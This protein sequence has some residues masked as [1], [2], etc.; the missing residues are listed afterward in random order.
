MLQI[1]GYQITAKIYESSN[2]IVYRGWHNQDSLP[3]IV[4]IPQKEYPTA[5][6]ITKYKQEYEISR[7]LSISGIARGY[8][9]QKYQNSLLMIF[10]DFGGESLKIWMESQKFSL[11]E[12][13]LIAIKISS[14][15][16]EIQQQ[17]IIHKDINPSNIIFNPTTDE[18]K[19]IDFGISTILFREN[20]TI[21]NPDIL[22]GTL[23]YISPEQTGRMN[24]VLDYRTDFYSLGVTFYEMLA[25]QLPFET[26]DPME[27]VHCHIAKQPIPLDEINPDIPK[28]VSK[29]VMKLLAK[30]AEERYQS[31]LGIK[32]DL[33]K[34]LKQLE[35][36]NTIADFSLGE[37][38]VSNKFQISQKLYGRE[39]QIAALL[40]AF[41]RI[42]QGTHEMLL[43]SG[44]S[45]IGK[46]SLVY[47]IHKP[48]VEQRGYF[49]SG[50]FDQFKRDLPYS[51]LIQCFQDLIRQLLTESAKKILN[52]QEKLLNVFG[53]N[54]Q[55]IIDVIP[56]VEFIVGKQPPV[57]QLG[58]VESQ[59][60]FNAIFKEFIYVFTK[61]EHPLVLFLDDLQWADSASL[62]LIQLIMTDTNSQYLLLLGAYRDNEVNSVHPLMLTLEEIQKTGMKIENINLS[63]LEIEQVNQLIADSLSCEVERAQP[64]GELIFQKTQGNPFFI[65]ELLKSLY[66]ENLLSFD[67]SQ[68]CWDW[69]IDKLQKIQITNNVV[70]LMINKIIKFD[71][72]TQNVLKLAACIG[73]RFDLDV[74][75]MINERS[76]AI[77]ARDLWAA[78]Q[79]GIILSLSETYKLSQFWEHLDGETI[80]YSFLHDRVQQAAYTLIP[81]DELP[82]VHLKIGQL[83]L[84]DLPES[85]VHE[86]IFDIVNH[87]NLGVELITEPEHK[88]QLSHLNLIAG[89]RAKSSTAYQTAATHLKLGMDC[90]SLNS[91][92]SDYQLTLDLYRERSECE[93]LI[94]NVDLAEELFKITID[95]AKSKFDKTD[96][97]YL[98]ITLNIT[99][100]KFS[101]AIA[102]GLAGLRL[103]GL[104]LF[105]SEDELPS[106]IATNL[107]EVQQALSQQKI[108]DLINL[109]EMTDP[110][111]KIS[112]NLL[113]QV[114]GGCYGLSNQNLL[115]WSILKMVN[116]SL[117]YG[118]TSASAFG[119]SCYGLLLAV[120]ED[121]QT[122][123]QF[124]DL[125][126][127]ISEKFYDPSLIG[128]IY[129]LFAHAMNPYVNHFK[130]N[131]AI[132][133]KSYQTCIECGDLVY[134]VWA[135]FFGIWSRFEIGKNLNEILE[136]SEKYLPMVRQ[137]KDQNM[138]FAF[139]SLQSMIRNLQD[140]TLEKYNLNS[141]AFNEVLGMEQW[142]NTSFYH[143]INW[144]SYLKAQLL[145]TYNHSADAVKI[146]Q[147]VEPLLAAN[148]GFFPITKFYFYYTL[149]LAAIYHQQSDIEKIATWQILENNC[150]KIK[151]WADNCPANF[152]HQ[153]FLVTAEMAQIS[154]NALEAMDLYDRA[155]ATAAEND[156]IQHQAL[157][158]ELGAKFWLTRGKEEIAQLYLRKAHYN[159]QLWGAKRKVAQLEEEYPQLL[160]KNINSGGIRETKI[161]SNQTSSGSSSALDISTVMKAAQAISS[162]IVLSKLLSQ[163]IK[164]VIENAGAQKG[165]LILIDRGELVIQATGEVD[166]NEV[167]VSQSVPINQADDIPLSIIN[168]VSRT[169]TDVVLTEATKE[170]IFTTDKYINEN[171]I[172]SV[173]CAPIVNQGQLIGIV[174]LE[175]NLTVGAF[176]AARL[177]VLKILSSQA[178]ISLENA[179]LYQT[180]EQKVQERT[181][182]LGQANQEIML[183]NERLKAE[184]IRMSAELEVT[185]KLQQMVLP[186]PAELSQVSGLEIASFM[187]PATEVGGDYYDILNYDGRVLIGIGDVTGHGLESGVLMIM[188]QTAVRSLLE[189]GETDLTRLLTVLNRTIYRNIER[190]GLDKNLTLIL[191][192]Y[193]DGTLRFSGQH[194]EIIIV[195]AGGIVEEINTIDLGFPIGLELNVADF[196][197]EDRVQLQPGDVVVLYTD[198]IT[199]APDMQGEEYGI[200]RLIAEV[201]KN[202]HLSAE[203]IKQ[204]IIT[205][206]QQ[207]IGEQRIYDDITLLVL[208]KSAVT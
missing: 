94:G 8:E 51:S 66:Q 193:Q 171:Q 69:D 187:E 166:G 139:T 121:Y 164:L 129:N 119:Y 38:D 184:N 21:C 14:I 205:D 168:F 127:K 46:S 192:D 163:L 1:P 204:R 98:Q 122:A 153:Y 195:R 167:V 58:P 32:T 148:F 155:I 169:Q 136:I 180:L 173:L 24:R 48:I 175:N 133:A 186:K 132:H 90:L 45:G 27:L 29:I 78:V 13:L 117:K 176:T 6:E 181:A 83:L 126:L 107:A 100:G 39:E 189:N 199:E 71:Q 197:A 76:L 91:W 198:G 188:A 150:Q 106:A 112:M 140:N 87:F 57:P 2:S 82:A 170:G 172:K 93:Y 36:S 207:H 123:Y 89:K 4:K 79:E 114:W 3:V 47:E 10:E 34:C 11:K 74:V 50:K 178:A 7:Q 206:L 191:L 118:N 16:G 12:F 200:E 141:D 137:M 44:Y 185:R 157:A 174:Y 134:G 77:T 162:E 64:L 9:I 182:Q 179:L 55:I 151:K 159:Y 52:W 183:L 88:K 73:N 154:G 60:R 138:I 105:N 203:E 147:E 144:F 41:D 108:A 22:E 101:E 125:S 115:V 110:E 42:S 23:A 65:T 208:K 61:P 130:T 152:L 158:N 43:I 202:Y 72:N 96:V 92:E 103:V 62:N 63:N 104:D 201:K 124:G 149:S 31:A 37:Q 99:V 5:T 102:A 49:I 196:M 54:G 120:Q 86:K 59:N 190:M 111:M 145:Y 75:A 160:T 85:E 26:T 80:T 15:L 161:S 84:K 56:E 128:K 81:I 109:P 146:C 70:E 194:E 25:H 113:I 17:N 33:E 142:Q 35:T 116:L 20:P 97:Y 67:F 18:V 143:G 53:H 28:P 131:L 135:L 165:V 177:E 95:R 156:F 68:G 30:T 19:I 40:R